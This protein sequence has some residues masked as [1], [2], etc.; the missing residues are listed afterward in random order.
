MLTALLTLQIIVTVVMIGAILMQPNSNDGMGGLG[1][2]GQPSLAV[3]NTSFL[4]KLTGVLAAIFMANSLLMAVVSSSSVSRE[5]K[6]IEKLQD[7]RLPNDAAPKKDLPASSPKESTEQ[8]KTPTQA[9]ASGD[10]SPGAPAIP[11]PEPMHPN[12]PAEQTAP[13]LPGEEGK[14]TQIPNDSAQ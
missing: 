5:D 11:N 10:A 8:K 9:P 12:A 7:T 3:D 14:P 4:S 13:T 1:S 2:G 6:I